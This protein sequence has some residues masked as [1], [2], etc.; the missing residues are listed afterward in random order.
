MGARSNHSEEGEQETE[1]G[2]CRQPFR[3]KATVTWARLGRAES[4]RT[5][6][7][8]WMRREKE[9]RRQARLTWLEDLG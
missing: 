4:K 9:E 1:G 3:Q 7:T 6:E 5:Q 2:C 8:D